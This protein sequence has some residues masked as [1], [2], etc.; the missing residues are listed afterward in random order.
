MVNI[1]SMIRICINP[2]WIRKLDGKSEQD[3]HASTALELF[4][5]LKPIK[6]KTL[7]LPCA[8]ISELPSNISSVLCTPLVC[9][10][11][12][13]LPLCFIDHFPHGF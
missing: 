2:T 7:L 3:A 9:F 6:I 5:C 1:F 12:N 13:T 4:K 8:P 11:E 10:H